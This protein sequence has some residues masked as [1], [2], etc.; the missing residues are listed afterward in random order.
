MEKN[1]VNNFGS[2]DITFEKGQ[3]STLSDVNGKKYIDFVSGIGVNC[4]G[5]NHPELVK[6]LQN[7]VAKQ[8]HISNYYVS[9][10]GLKYAK[11][12][13]ETTGY[14]KVYFGNSGAEANEAAIKLARK[15]G[16]LVSTGKMASTNGTCA[17]SDKKRNVIVTLEKSFHGRTIATLCA[18][19]QDKFHPDCFAPYPEGFRTIKANDYE[20]L[21][22]A[23][24][25]TVCAFMLECVQGEG[26]VN[27]VDADWAKAAA[28]AARKAGAIVIAD[29]VQTGMARTGS[30]LAS[31]ELGFDP[32]VV[33]LA[34]GIAGGVPMGACIYKGIAKDVFVAGDHQSTFAGNPLAVAAAETV[35]NIIKEKEFL[36]NV[37]KMGEYIRNTVK[38]WNLPCIK[39]VRGKGLMIGIDIEETSKFATAGEVQKMCLAASEKGTGL[40]ISTAGVKTLRFLPPLV[41][42]KEEVD[43]GLEILKSILS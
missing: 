36:E 13:L 27:L 7:Q 3:G 9:D 19:G 21:K 37:S 6:A 23:F 30:L 15:Y 8:I 41:I 11:N 42:T 43:T 1:V 28:E 31:T 38:S 40:C 25:E 17:V 16:Y 4:L 33:T 26:G 20:C 14:D 29:E 10:I 24:D 39:E 35:L 22:T 12:L 5:H 2:F 18:T 34:K 32:E